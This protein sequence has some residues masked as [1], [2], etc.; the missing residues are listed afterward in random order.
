MNTM[1]MQS[2]DDF[3]Q[4]ARQQGETQRLLFVFTRIELPEGH[5]PSQAA[6]YHAGTGGHLA[7]VA[8]VDKTI[9][10]VGSFRALAKEADKNLQDWAACFVAVLPG[11]ADQGPSALAI[12][13]ALE[14]MVEDVRIGEVKG[15]LAFDHAGAPLHSTAT[16]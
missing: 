5:T 13:H 8:Y 3:L 4:I 15:Y 16:P 6:D 7:P 9:G 11:V 2:F 1:K 14:S 12:D 10:Q